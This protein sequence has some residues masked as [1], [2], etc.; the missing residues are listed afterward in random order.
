MRKKIADQK[1]QL[2]NKKTMNI[3]PL[4]NK[5]LK[6]KIEIVKSFDT[7][8]IIALLKFGELKGF[9]RR[10]DEDFIILDNEIWE[11]ARRRRIMIG[12]VVD[13]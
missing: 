10:N 4:K 2:N 12:G 3:I 8:F 13:D 7:S 9:N 6:E 11:R 1:S 5:S